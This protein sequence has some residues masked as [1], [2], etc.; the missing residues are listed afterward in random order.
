MFIIAK[1]ASVKNKTNF[2]TLLNTKFVAI[3]FS[4]DSTVWNA[5]RFLPIQKSYPSAIKKSRAGSI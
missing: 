1:K 2:T 3:D 5:S 4:V